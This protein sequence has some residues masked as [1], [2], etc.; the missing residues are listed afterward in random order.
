MPDR[1]AEILGQPLSIGV[2]GVI[3]TVQPAMGTSEHKPR[4]VFA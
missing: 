2:R 1:Q 3:I 4:R